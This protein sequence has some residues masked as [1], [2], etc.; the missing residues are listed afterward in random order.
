MRHKHITQIQYS[1][2]KKIIGQYGDWKSEIASS[3]V[4]RTDAIYVG[5]AGV[6][7]FF[8]FWT[9]PANG[10]SSFS[11]RTFVL[12]K[13]AHFTYFCTAVFTATLRYLRQTSCFTL[14]TT[15]CLCCHSTTFSLSIA[16]C[17]LPVE[18]NKL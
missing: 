1:K 13:H 8:H 7:D 9:A 4:V 3:S 5:P 10:N 12:G 2:T 14:K 11:F 17:L 16:L 6:H 18:P 15:D